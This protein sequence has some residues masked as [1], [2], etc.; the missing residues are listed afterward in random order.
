[1]SYYRTCPDCGATLDPGERCD[2]QDKKKEE[3]ERRANLF[4]KERDSDQITF[5]WLQE[6][7]RV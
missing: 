7:M 5:N 1:M 2:C 6:E 3:Q 4:V